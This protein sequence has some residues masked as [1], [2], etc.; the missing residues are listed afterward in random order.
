MVFCDSI[1]G[2]IRDVI[3][4]ARTFPAP[5]I[6]SNRGPAGGEPIDPQPGEW[7]SSTRT[8]RRRSAAQSL[9]V[10]ED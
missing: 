4:M 5:A 9:I 8:V 10:E 1:A 7:L 6:Y 3:A 2:V